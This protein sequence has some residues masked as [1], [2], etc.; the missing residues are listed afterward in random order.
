[1]RLL[2]RTVALLALATLLPAAADPPPA[3]WV[4]RD[5]GQPGAPG[6]IDVT[7]APPGGLWM[8]EGSGAGIFSLAD[9]FQFVY[10]LVKGDASISAR[11]LNASGGDAK[12]AAAGL[13]IRAD[14][15]PEAPNFFYAMSAGSG[16]VVTARGQPGGETD[17][18]AEVGPRSFPEAN[19]ALRL[20]RVGGEITGFY[21]RDGELWSQAAFPPRSLTALPDEALLGLAVTSHLDGDLTSAAFD[22]VDLRAGPPAPYSLVACGRDRAVLA[23]WQSLPGAM[24]YQVYRGPMGASASQLVRI[25]TEQIT[26]TSFTDV[27]GELM[28][29]VPYTYAVRGL[30]PGTGGAPVE[31]PLVAGTATPAALPPDWSGCSL[32]E[33]RQTGAAAYDPTRRSFTVRGSGGGLGA[34]VANNVGVADEIYYVGTPVTGDGQVTV[35]LTRAPTGNGQALLMLRDGLDPGAR[36]VAIGPTSNRTLFISSRIAPG[37]AAASLPAT[38]TLGNGVPV[39]VTLRLVR[40]GNLITWLYSVDGG[41]TFRSPGPPVVFSA[42]GGRQVDLPQ[43]LMA[44]L[45]V[46]ARNRDQV[47]E[48]E[49]ANYRLE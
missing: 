49:F 35:T 31:G 44:G 12:L 3:P 26:G 39:P 42:L 20:Q 4:A 30:F 32:R 27:G 33:P 48:A 10:Q 38:T 37:G 1:M 19:L 45:V 17:R 21:S 18:P 41:R 15:A 29:G 9:S 36:Y 2:F 24:G 22:R 25:T 6:S 16:L 13:M 11:F 47:S 43:T 7:G 23:Q 28:N 8:L 46:T 34:G 5:I 14:E 40:R